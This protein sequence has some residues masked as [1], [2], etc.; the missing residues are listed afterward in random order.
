MKQ[1]LKSFKKQ[2]PDP[3]VGKEIVNRTK[4]IHSKIVDKTSHITR[5]VTW[6]A[7]SQTEEFSEL[8]EENIPSPQ[9][10]HHNKF[11][12]NLVKNVDMAFNYRP[13]EE[14]RPMFRFQGVSGK[15]ALKIK[16][17]GINFSRNQLPGQNSIQTEQ[18]DRGRATMGGSIHDRNTSLNNFVD[19]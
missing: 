19:D 13:G 9:R 16:E 11:I 14:D 4:E 7:E 8:E 6:K 5:D 2:Q 15:T 17:S 12:K 18:I 10:K 3:S 1:N